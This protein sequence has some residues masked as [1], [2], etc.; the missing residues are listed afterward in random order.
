MKINSIPLALMLISSVASAVELGNTFFQT[1]EA[2]KQMI[3]L[4]VD[5]L[6]VHQ[7]GAPNVGAIM[8]TWMNAGYPTGRMFFIGSDAGRIYTTGQWDGKQHLDETEVDRNGHPIECAGVRPYMIPTE[9]WKSFIHGQIKLGIDGKGICILPEE[10][11]AHVTGGYGEAFK[12]IYKE[13][14]G[15]DWVPP[16]SSPDAYYKSSKLLC[17]LY[18]ELVED[19]LEYTKEYAAEKGREVKYLLPIHPLLSHA[20][21]LMTYAS[22]RSLGLAEEGLDGFVGQ[23]WTGPIAW[24]MSKAEGKQMD[25]NNDFFESAY[26]MYSYFAYLVKG[27]SVP[28]YMLADP[29]EDDPQYSWEDYRKWYNQCLVAMLQFPWMDDFEVM[30][31]PDRVFL[32][33]Y[34]MATGT[35]GPEDYRRALMVAFAVLQE[36]GDLPPAVPPGGDEIPDLG[37]LVMD[38][39]SWQ[40][41]GPQ[42]SRMESIHGFTVPLLRHGIPIPVVPIERFYLN[43]ETLGELKT[44]VLSY[45][46]QKPQQRPGGSTPLADWVKAGGTLIY[47]GGEDAYNSV[48]EWWRQEGYDSPQQEL[49]EQ[50]GI[51]KK[52]EGSPVANTTIPV[53]QGRFLWYNKSA[54]SLADDLNGG[55][56]VMDLLTKAS[57]DGKPLT[58]PEYY[59]C[60]RGDFLAVRACGNNYA[61]EG[62]FLDLL[63]PNLPVVK[64]PI[65]APKQVGLFL[66]IH[67]DQE[68][69]DAQRLLFAGPRAKSVTSTESL[70][71]VELRS[72]DNTPATLR[73]ACLGAKAASITAKAKDTGAA[74]EVRHEYDEASST[75][76]CILPAGVKGAM[77]EVKWERESSCDLLQNERGH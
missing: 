22:G 7:H 2:Y 63:N 6:V 43:P 55:K 26:L 14:Y 45:D 8:R 25:R 39:L 72:P 12:R 15:K 61:A 46:A 53:G 74:V 29:V 47:L 41:G 32:P 57:A 18:Y 16:H 58:Q 65:L 66:D 36:I 60:K 5:F 4:D 20:N 67:A 76:L 1:N 34:T 10:P 30:P 24:G 62:T 13:R 42:G 11:L 37:F 75:L 49:W 9:G 44:L 54:A 56:I 64:N 71:Q 70:L 50:L 48:E 52:G 51:W 38:S 23:V 68:R 59:S 31:W 27:T 73:L 35:P 40:R 21:G 28:C 77:L 17:E 69:Q 3:A 33:G 19:T